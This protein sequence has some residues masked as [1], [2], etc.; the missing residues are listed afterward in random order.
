MLF[1]KSQFVKLSANEQ[2]MGMIIKIKVP[3]SAG[4]TKINPFLSFS[5]VL[6]YYK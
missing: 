5:M 4:S 6:L 2:K 3:I 1:N